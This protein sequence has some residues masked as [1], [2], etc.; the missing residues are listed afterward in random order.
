MFMGMAAL[1]AYWLWR[2]RLAGRWWGFGMGWWAAMLI[3]MSLLCKKL[4]AF[5]LM[6]G[7]VG[8]MYLSRFTVRN[9]LIWILILTPIAYMTARATVLWSADGLVNQIAH[10]I[11]DRRAD[12]LQTR[13]T[14]EDRLSAKA[15]QRPV[16]GWGGWGRNRV[17]NKYGKDISITDGMWII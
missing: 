15:L 16:F 11:S 2:A 6:A 10:S 17:Y 4:G 9:V 5:I 1:L 12:S 3:V 8:T 14:N 13:L 7:G